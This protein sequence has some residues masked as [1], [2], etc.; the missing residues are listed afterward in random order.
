M[1]VDVVT[2]VVIIINLIHSLVVQVRLFP[3]SDEKL[4]SIRVGPVVSHGKNSASVVLLTKDE[5][6]LNEA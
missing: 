2:V 3:V 4:R 5:N 6:V 1:V